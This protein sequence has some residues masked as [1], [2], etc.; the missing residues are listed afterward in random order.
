LEGIFRG[1]KGVTL[2]EYL[3]ALGLLSI[4][5]V[6]FLTAIHTGFVALSIADEK[7]VAENL[8]RT[9]LEQIKGSDYKPSGKYKVIESPAGY[10]IEVETFPEGAFIQRIKVT[11]SR[12]SKVLTVVE[13]YKVKQD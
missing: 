13:D 1:Q 7:A 6:A 4:I 11:I 12:G 8:A 3:V 2:I 10:S 5:G 9:Q